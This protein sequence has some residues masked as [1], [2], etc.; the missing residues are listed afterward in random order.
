MKNLD[1]SISILNNR[2]IIK[3]IQEFIADPDA[4]YKVSYMHKL[5][6]LSEQAVKDAFN[7]LLKSR[8]IKDANK[9]CNVH[10]LK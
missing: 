9:N 5:T 10:Y 2:V 8:S 3:V 1:D 4:P 6:N 7:L